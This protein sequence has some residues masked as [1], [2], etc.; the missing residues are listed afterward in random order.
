MTAD[1]DASDKE[2]GL[3]A[4][5]SM[6]W[7]LRRALQLLALGI[8]AD[9]FLHEVCRLAMAAGGGAAAVIL[10]AREG[11]LTPAAWAGTLPPAFLAASFHLQD[12]PEQP[13]SR[14]YQTGAAIRGERIGEGLAPLPWAV[15]LKEAE[16][17][18]CLAVPLR[19]AGEILGVLAVFQ[20]G[21]RTF[22]EAAVDLTESLACLAAVGILSR[23][24][25]EDGRRLGA[26]VAKGRGTEASARMP[27]WEEEAGI[28][29]FQARL[30]G[31]RL[32]AAN[33]ALARMLGW[34][35]ADS[36]LREFVLPDRV[37]DAAAFERLLAQAAQGRV[38]GCEAHFVRRDGTTASLCLWAGWEET[39]GVLVGVALDQSPLKELQAEL[40]RLRQSHRLLQEHYLGAA[41]LSQGEQEE[42]SRTLARERQV[43]DTALSLCEAGVAAFTREGRLSHWNRALEA[44]TGLKREE[45][46]GKEVGQVLPGLQTALLSREG[47]ELRQ[48]LDPGR[49]VQLHPGMPPAVYEALLTPLKNARGEADGGVIVMRRL[50]EL[51]VAAS[52]RG[53][54]APPSPPAAGEEAHR[55]R[56]ERLEALGSLAGSLARD[57][58]QILA[59]ML[60]YAEMAQ[61]A[62]PEEDPARARLAQ[63]LKA[64]RRGRDLVQQILAFSR[65]WERRPQPQEA[66]EG[67][68]ATAPRRQARGRILLAAGEESQLDLWREILHSLGFEVHLA[69]NSQEALELFQARHEGPDLLIAD[70]NLAPMRGVELIQAVLSLHPGLPVI[71]CLDPLDLVTLEQAKKAGVREF[72]LK[73]WSLSELTAALDRIL[74]PPGPRGLAP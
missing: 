19:A 27:G 71:L 10:L 74:P 69:Q 51:P 33:H 28:G 64:G 21:G 47:G 54:M 4:S 1:P 65:P 56:R 23:R 39:R 18:A 30:P 37:A 34:E 52:G 59:V 70:Q 15:A 8:T 20:A 38:Q 9:S 44:L 29:R 16:L 12:D 53:G 11:R 36:L 61:A 42:L 13:F 48:L 43:A 72:A 50:P 55:L 17:E 25:E 32:I 46:C 26:E 58:D 7:A 6:P 45:V 41:L 40:A 35:D 67:P 14:A 57:F 31:F 62:L 60:G 5:A 63:V 22:V 49:P 24:Q 66:K 73:P 2:A 68:E 3:L